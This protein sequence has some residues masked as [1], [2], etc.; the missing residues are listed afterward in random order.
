MPAYVLAF[1]VVFGSM[2]YSFWVLAHPR[3]PREDR[4]FAMSMLMSLGTAVVGFIF[5]KATK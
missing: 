4:Q 5:G 1:L 3:I 2:V